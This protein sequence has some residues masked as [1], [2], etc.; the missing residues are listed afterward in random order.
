MDFRKAI[1]LYDCD[2]EEANIQLDNSPF[3]DILG[4]SVSNGVVSITENDYWNYQFE[5]TFTTDTNNFRQNETET[6]LSSK[7][8]ENTDSSHNN[9]TTISSDTQ[10]TTTETLADD[11][12][13]LSKEDMFKIGGLV[14]L[15]VGL[16]IGL[17]FVIRKFN[18]IPKIKVAKKRTPTKRLHCIKD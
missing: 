6:I 3:S 2:D 14:A 7:N 10:E 8:E 11:K 12:V 13:F 16:I 17:A 15:G 5:T 1:N 18:Q 9:A 4:E